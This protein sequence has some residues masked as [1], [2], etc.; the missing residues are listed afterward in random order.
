MI[1]SRPVEQVPE[2]MQPF[3][4]L[5]DCWNRTQHT[6]GQM[7]RL[8]NAR[9]FDETIVT[10]AVAGSLGRREQ[11][12]ASDVDLIVVTDGEPSN[13]LTWKVWDTLRPLGLKLPKPEGIYGRPVTVEQL[14]SPDS[15]GIIDEDVAVFGQRMQ[16]LIEGR[17]VWGAEQFQELQRRILERFVLAHSPAAD[18]WRPL[19]DD[20][21]RYHR[22]LC[23]HYR[24]IERERRGNWRELL[25]KAGHSRLMGIAGLLILLAE[26]SRNGASPFEFVAGGLSQTPL[27]RLAA[28]YRR[29]GDD[30]LETVLRIY[31]RFLASL[32]DGS[33][34]SRFEELRENATTLKREVLRFILEQVERGE[35]PRTFLEHLIL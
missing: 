2:W 31:D 27:E 18:L 9:T 6:V 7:R 24:R 30:G 29:A 16:L 14:C 35:W 4:T 15:L 1:D 21:L 8:L 25:V 10:V 34:S 20:L 26:S 33:L 32:I 5:T 28:A 22:S 23:V 11:T 17:P 12:P 3:D 19:L 13:D